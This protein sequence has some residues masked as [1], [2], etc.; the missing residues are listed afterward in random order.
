MKWNGTE[1]YSYT[2]AA[3]KG[4]PKWPISCCAWRE[5]LVSTLA[6][7]KH[8]IN[9]MKERCSFDRFLKGARSINHVGSEVNQVQT[10][11]SPSQCPGLQGPRE[12]DE[13]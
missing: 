6:N 9:F 3:T 12:E 4:L 11:D 7:C 8:F 13:Y 5:C 10:P 1:G 2:V